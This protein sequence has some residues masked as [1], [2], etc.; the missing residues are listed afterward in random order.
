[1]FATGLKEMTAK[2]SVKKKFGYSAVILCKF[3]SFSAGVYFNPRC[4]G[5]INFPWQEIPNV[6][7][8]S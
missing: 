1:M 8:I 7:S 5:Q 3:L 4:G 2:L 6:I